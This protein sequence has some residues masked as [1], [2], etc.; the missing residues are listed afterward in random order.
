MSLLFIVLLII[1]ITSLLGL[2]AGIL[3]LWFAARIKWLSNYLISFAV[4]SLLAVAFLHLLPEL[5]ASSPNVSMSFIVVLV[6]ILTFYLLEKFLIVYHCH[7]NEHCEVHVSSTPLII[8][9]DTLHNFLDGMV[10]ASAFFA[11]FRLGIVAAVA[12]LFHELPQEIGDFAVL[13]H[14]GMTRWRII[15]WNVISALASVG[16]A[17][18]VWWLDQRILLFNTW[19]L[20]FAAGNFIYIACTDLMPMTN[21]QRRTRDIT[22]H[23]LALALGLAAIVA[24]GR[25]LPEVAI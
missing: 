10:I 16:G 3:L 5:V 25:L 15:F 13:W 2:T 21:S 1:A 20:A 24:V 14:N 23:I 22:G 11:D 7:H 19:L 17:L 4:G 9:S 6:G 18:L 8:I 12:V